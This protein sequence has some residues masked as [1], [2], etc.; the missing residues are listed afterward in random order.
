MERRVGKL[1]FEPEKRLI[2]KNINQFKILK[3]N[4]IIKIA[5]LKST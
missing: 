4:Y 3:K 5:Q 2:R 1:F